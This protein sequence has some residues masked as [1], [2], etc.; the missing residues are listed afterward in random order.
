MLVG[1]HVSIAGGFDK[2]IDRTVA[3]GGNILQ[4]FASSPRSLSTSDFPDDVLELYLKKKHEAS[5]G[6]HFF[7]GVYLVNL[8]H[9][10]TDY[11]QASINS[12]LFYQ[13][14]ASKISGAGTIFHL[15]S[16]KGLGFGA[17]KKQ[18]AQAIEKVLA[19]TPDNVNLY[20]ENAAGQSGAIGAQ[21]SEL[22]SLYD[23]ISSRELQKKLKVCYDTQHGFSAG[24]DI[25]DNAKVEA[26]VKIIENELGASLI[27][28]IH[29][30]DSMVEL[31][32]HKDR[33]QNIGEGS[34]GKEGFRAFI[35]HPVFNHLPYLL[36]VP[37]KD[38]SGPQ[39]S[40]VSTLKAL[41]V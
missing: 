39:L 25:R 16:H 21:L 3:I 7:H 32:G 38:K 6:S 2:S 13:R 41:F 18:V 36:E 15:G 10:N 14:L 12:L 22:R 24:Y 34:I 30:N 5:I 11:V 31:G 23:S 19:S 4:T 9:E 40:D 33:H 28:V 37:G 8:A 26:T 35:A 27:G 29:A 17:V 1:G 20:L